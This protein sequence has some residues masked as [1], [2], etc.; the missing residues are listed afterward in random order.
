MQARETWTDRWKEGGYREFDQEQSGS[1]MCSGA[2][3]L[4][5]NKIEA[6]KNMKNA[7]DNMIKM[8][9]QLFEMFPPNILLESNFH[10]YLF[11]IIKKETAV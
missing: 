2:D 8:L 3:S 6:I 9:E 4:I 1:R 7:R 11:D 5:R 10:E